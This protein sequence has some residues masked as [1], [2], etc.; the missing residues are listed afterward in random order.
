MRMTARS[1]R[2]IAP[3]GPGPG[4]C[5][6]T[7][8]WHGREQQQDRAAQNYAAAMAVGATPY[9]YPGG[10][11][12]T[13]DFLCYLRPRSTMASMRRRPRTAE[14]AGLRSEWRRPTRSESA[15]PTATRPALA[16]G[17]EPCDDRTSAP[18]ARIVGSHSMRSS[19]RR[20]TQLA[21]AP[22]RLALHKWDKTSES[23]ARRPLGPR[24]VPPSRRPCR[25]VGLLQTRTNAPKTST[26]ATTCSLGD[27]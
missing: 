20:S 24:A 16:K 13:T 22:F 9:S 6:A 5:A 25:R 8:G 4:V 1:A 21:E 11:S 3:A 7:G 23:A 15:F 19:S 26:A 17:G 2:P 10:R 18:L 14:A 27:R 12:S